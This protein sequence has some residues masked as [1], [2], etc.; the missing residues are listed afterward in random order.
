MKAGRPEISADF[1][2]WIRPHPARPS[3]SHSG[4]NIFVY[5]HL[6]PGDSDTVANLHPQQHSLKQEP[7]PKFLGAGCGILV[8]SAATPARLRL[9]K[10][11]GLYRTCCIGRKTSLTSTRSQGVSSS[12]RYTE[13]NLL[14][15]FQSDR[16]VYLSP[17]IKSY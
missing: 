13:L 15:R 5:I 6:R 8:G 4:V 14:K 12:H 11:H 3:G 16:D 1:T 17:F 9:F 7:S 2:P 10:D